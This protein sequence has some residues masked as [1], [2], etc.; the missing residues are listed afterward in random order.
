VNETFDA[1]TIRQAQDTLVLDAIRD[2][3][4][5]VGMSAKDLAHQFDSMLRELVHLEAISG[6]SDYVIVEE[7]DPLD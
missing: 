1:E 2:A 3:F 6:V 4:N 7:F 5:Q